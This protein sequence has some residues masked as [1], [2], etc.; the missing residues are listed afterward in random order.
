MHMCHAM[1][2]EVRGQLWESIIF[3][4]CGPWK[5]NLGCLTYTANA[6]NHWTIL[7]AL[8]QPVKKILI[9]ILCACVW[10]P[11]CIHVY[12]MC[13]WCPWRPEEGILTP[14]TGVTAVMSLLMRVLGAEPGL[15]AGPT[16]SWLSSSCTKY[17]FYFTAL[18]ST[19]CTCSRIPV[20]SCRKVSL[21][22]A[23]QSSLELLESDW[24][25]KSICCSCRRLGFG[26][27][28]SYSGSQPSV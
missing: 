27:Q 18:G 2:V 24:V 23:I 7:M 26:F 10:N 9:F 3:F 28:H 8:Y 11:A 4:Y 21:I 17:G 16:L 12:H 14:G 25:A 13:I 20:Y 1:H 5:L 22:K 19:P 15:C 6:F